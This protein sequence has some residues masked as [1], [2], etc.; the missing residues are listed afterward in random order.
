LVRGE[1]EA[2]DLQGYRGAVRSIA[3]ASRLRRFPEAASL[4]TDAALAVGVAVVEIGATLS[5]AGSQHH[6]AALDPGAFT[7]LI[8]GAL[9]LVARRQAPVGVLTVVFATTLAYRLLNYPDG[10]NHLAFL[11]A[12]V[13]V[14]M[15]GRRWVGWASLALA[16]IAFVWLPVWVGV[17]SFP[18]VAHTTGLLAW[19][20]AIGC[21]A[22]IARVRGE[23]ARDAARSR[24]EEARR[25]AS[26]ERLRVAREL[27]DTV[28]H[29]LSLIHV[30][31]NVARHLMD[32]R[33]EQTRA[34]LDAIKSASKEAL[35]ELRSVLDLLR[36]P[37]EA[38][39]RAPTAGL[40]RLDEL[41]A[42]TRAVGLPVQALTEGAPSALPPAVDVAAFRIVQEALTN[43]TRHAPNAA[44]SV[45]I[46]YHPQELLVQVENEPCGVAPNETVN[47]SAGGGNGIA[48]MRERAMVLGGDLHA[49]PRADGGF[50]VLARLPLTESR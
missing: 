31:A 19:V 47:G 23:R 35:D 27:H 39:P 2:P 44:T 29:N 30:H 12:V 6:R 32:E 50:R 38:A 26:E 16:Y 46:V 37:G 4:R 10:P 41:I 42:R 34:A 13:T 25:R 20:L 7:L 3:T 17:E 28:A 18:G 11:V 1:D 14:I 43:A 24:R 5:I 33:P 21:A 15:A 22:E 8:A 49:G 40:E 48:G 36:G 45:R 9:A